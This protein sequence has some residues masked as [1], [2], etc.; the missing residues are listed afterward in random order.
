LAKCCFF[1]HGTAVSA[2]PSDLVVLICPAGAES[3][4]IRSRRQKLA[5]LS[6]NSRRSRAYPGTLTSLILR[7]NAFGMIRW[8]QEAEGFAD[9]GLTFG[10]P[11][12]VRYAEAYGAKGWRIERADGLVPALEAAFKAGGVHLVAVPVDYSENI[13]VLVDELRDR[14]PAVASA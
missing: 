8:K 12:F 3:A 2:D 11:D 6:G 7:D 5:A 14:M 13:R 9:W 4:P 10:N 1:V